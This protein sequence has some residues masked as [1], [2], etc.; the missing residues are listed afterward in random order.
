[1][2]RFSHDR[3][4]WHDAEDVCRSLGGYLVTISSQQEN[5][6]LES[7]PEGGSHWLGLRG[8]CSNL[9]C[10]FSWSRDEGGNFQD[11]NP[12]RPLPGNN[13]NCVYKNFPRSSWVD[14][15]CTNDNRYVCEFIDDCYPTN[16]CGDDQVCVSTAE[17][18]GH[19]CANIETYNECSSNPC[20]NGATCDDGRGNYTCR[21]A[22]GWQGANCETDVDEC[23]TDGGCVHGQCSNS[24][25]SFSCDC[26]HDDIAIGFYGDRCQY[27]IDE[28]VD[29]S[30]VHG[31]CVD[32]VNEY[33]CACDDGYQ[34]K[35]C[36]EEKR[37]SSAVSTDTGLMI[38]VLIIL[39]LLV[40]SNVAIGVFL[41]RTRRAAR[42]ADYETPRTNDVV[43]N[44][45]AL[46]MVPLGNEEAT[47]RYEGM[48]KTNKTR[49]NE[50][51]T[52]ENV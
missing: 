25:G 4:E 26:T 14:T 47:A 18:R 10:S 37:S 49:G 52:Y 42:S 29:H 44:K 1:M 30:C 15:I 11:W 45:R 41:V 31:K 3:L 22:E 16:P 38:A 48:R 19:T 40:A 46:P 12:D 43:V 6:F 33:V 27:N 32:G 24:P 17:S 5:D 9:R 21:C 39:A 34:G 36:E 20:Q 8:S 28:C 7:L 51:D 50:P 2:C 23:H 35:Y 13:Y